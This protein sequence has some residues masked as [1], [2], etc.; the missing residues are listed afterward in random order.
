M[1]RSKRGPA[2]FDLLGKGE[3][4]DTESLKTPE[5]WS[6]GDPP[7][8]ARASAPLTRENVPS[9]VPAP[10]PATG[11]AGGSA[12]FIELDG[13]RIRLSFTSVLAAL[14]VFAALV[15]LLSA[16]EWGRWSGE[17]NGFKR[18]HAAGRA[19]YSAGTMDEIEAARRQPPATHVVS[20]LLRGADAVER[21][22][23]DPAADMGAGARE[24][25]RWI[26]DYTYIVAQE[27]SQG[28][29]DDARQAQVFLTQYGVATELVRYPSGSIQLITTEG[30]NRRNQTQRQMAEQRLRKVH[31]V[32]AKY[33]ETGGRY[34][35][36]GYFK[37]FQGETW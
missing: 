13:G 25:P 34:K 7:P 28:R 2:L 37:T 9:S 27:F 12:R 18:G 30:F 23:T 29:E 5:W 32:G 22:S 8:D 14:A 31:T 35:L 4:T 11:S 15:V 36:E 10:A 19:S 21:D 6:S 26:Q 16:F 20:S 17:R 24:Q 3:E 33:F 1:P